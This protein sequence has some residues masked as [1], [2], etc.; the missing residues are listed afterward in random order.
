MADLEQPNPVELKVMLLPHQARLVGLFDAAP[1]PSTGHRIWLCEQSALWPQQLPLW[2]A[3]LVLRLRERTGHPDDSTVVICPCRRAQLSGPW[4]SWPPGRVETL[5]IDQV[6][7]GERRIRSAALSAP[8]TA[9]TVRDVRAGLTDTRALFTLAQRIFLH[10]CADRP[11]DFD[12]LTV[13]GPIEVLTWPELV[14][15][16]LRL[17][18]ERWRAR[19]S[20][21]P[22]LE[23]VEVSR[24]VD[25]QGAE[26]AQ[27]ALESALRRRLVDAWLSDPVA[28]THR[29][30]NYLSHPAT[31]PPTQP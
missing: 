5:N 11:V 4:A 27:L 14:W 12:D 24:R 29:F 28:R 18:V 7:T 20:S 21:R 6:W 10:D 13:L 15:S 17:R 3:G 23:V 31:D 16:G 22:C 1:P 2:D 30:L 25:R 9:G 19:A 26:I 8:V